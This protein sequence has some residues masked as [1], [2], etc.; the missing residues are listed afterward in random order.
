MGTISS[1]TGLIS[2]LNIQQLVSQL[3]AI[4]S[5]PLNLLQ[6]QITTTQQKQTTYTEL[7]A[8]VLTAKAA[9]SRLAK[10][11]AYEVKK[12]TSSN[13]SVLTAS[14]SS[15]AP[16]EAY[17]FRVKSLV[18]THQVVSQGFADSNSTKLGSGTLSFAAAAARV[19]K[20]TSLAS[21]N[22]FAG[23]RGGV[24]RVID[25]TGAS[26]EIDLRFVSTVDDVLEAFNRQT[27][28]GVT[29]RIAGD[30]IVVS[31][32]S[33]GSGSLSIQ[34]IGSGYAASDLGIAGVSATGTLGGSDLV[35][36]ADATS[37][38]AIND[39]LGVRVNGLVDDMQF[40]LRD[41]REIAVNL[42]GKLR[43]QT[44][45]AELN[46]GNGVRA[47]N[48]QRIIKVTNHAGQSAEVDLSGATTVQDVA[49]A[50]SNA[51]ISVGVSLAGS[52][53]LITDSSGVE[54]GS[55]KVED[56]VGYAAVDLGIAGESTGT[57]ITGNDVYRLNSIGGVIRAITY[58]DGNDG[59]LD[60]Q[61]SANGN[62]LTL[63]DH[64]SGQGETTVESLNGSQ[65]VRDL[66]LLADFT[67]NTLNS[68]S[69]LAGL[70]TV[71]LSSLR[72]GN[73]VQAGAVQFTRRDGSAVDLDFTGATSLADIVGIINQDGRLK[74]SIDSGGTSLDIVDSTTGPGTLSASGITATQL[75]LTSATAGRLN[76]GNLHLQHIAENTTLA[77]LNHGA[78]I[79][80][81][82]IRITARN[83]ASATLNIADSGHK[84]IGDVIKSINGLSIGVTARINGNGDGIELVDNTGGTGVITVAEEGGGFAAKDLGLLGS[85]KDGQA[86][87]VGSFTTTVEISASDTL[88]TLMGKIN[89][90]GVGVRAHVLNDGT[91]F[92]PYRLTFT[93]TRSGS[94]GE[95]AFNTAGSSLSFSTLTEARDATLVV[96]D[97]S[98][99]APII[100]SS[101][102]NTITGVV[103]GLTLNLT[104]VS[105]DAVQVSV[106][107]D[108]EAV[109]TDMQTFVKTFNDTL[110]RI[111][112]LTLYNQETEERG[113]LLGE[114]A[115]SRI[116]SQLWSST[117]MVANI[118]GVT[119]TRLLDIGI[120]IPR[121]GDPGRAEGSPPR[122][123]IDEAR[124]RE[125]FS[126]RP[127]EVKALLT[128]L[129]RGA[130][131]QVV[132]RGL[133]ARLDDI[134]N[135]MT[136]SAGGSIKRQTDA[137]QAKVDLYKDR[138]T[139]MQALLD[140]KET[141]LYAQFQAMESALASLQSQQ[142]SLA[143][144]ASLASSVGG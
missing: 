127:N 50:F 56:V 102:S 28:V 64:T 86:S 115:V 75:G 85:S 126:E 24:V 35:R 30:G 114:S 16:V 29:A 11:S 138:V 141:R 14:A 38:R 61:I 46:D 98:S 1:G 52:K 48:G 10:P 137:L 15:S 91:P 128:D 12:A 33:G 60:I 140:Q 95:M 130:D 43:F 4:E 70:N 3:I 18:T 62:G 82:R 87:L 109:I 132:K 108:V 47:D 73:G 123:Q 9:I 65:A 94:A 67:G 136:T 118:P 84:N 121:P 26:T 39:G 59:A 19:D 78:G 117:S 77:S 131:G 53:L 106:T 79:R 2:G 142:S 66:G 139:D 7:N 133:A 23:V 37:L 20:S 111:D 113:L 96:G 83:G 116:T 8:R 17:T 25:A 104:G 27:R 21:L 13:T 5:R 129:T 72:G 125:V 51:G 92:A 124:F 120:S 144:L 32:A 71:L 6:N 40:T 49:T 45:L 54:K 119:L 134:V 110:D 68:R 36:L 63:V 97:P 74:A 88:D 89:N 103:N 31:D 58:A 122:L 90:A 57:A 105:D 112:E 81:G 22:G 93:S 76:S 99:G 41:G 80:Y 44:R 100:I 143:S 55:L 107:R 34:D 135:E 101:S 42:S 69:L